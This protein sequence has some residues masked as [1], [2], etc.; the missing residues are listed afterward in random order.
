MNASLLDMLD[1][2][3]N[4]DGPTLEQIRAQAQAEADA[5]GIPIAIGW[6]V[7]DTTGEKEYGYCPASVAPSNAFVVEVLETVQPYRGGRADYATRQEAR[8]DRLE[9]AADRARS[10]S[11]SRFKRARG[12]L[13]G[14]EP[15]QPILVGHHSERRHR[16]ALEK[17]DTNM[18]AAIDADERAKDLAGRAAGVGT[19]GI[20]S[21]D[22]EALVKLREKLAGMEAEQ[23]RMKQANQVIRKWLKK[24]RARCIAELVKQGFTESLAGKLLEPDFC[25]RIGFADYQTKNNNA[26][27]RRVRERIEHLTRLAANTEEG[28]QARSKCGTVVY[29]IGDNRVQIVFPGKPKPE[30]RER[31][32]AAGFRWAP[33]AGAW[34]RHLNNAGKYH[35]G[36]FI[37]WFDQHQ[38]AA[39]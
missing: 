17:H 37:K 18:R 13:D 22:P 16:R 36:E 4:E 9:N 31:L 19:G 24:D 15:G 12:A 25:G 6:Q 7:N 33:S 21:D 32:K 26:N 11:A 34:Q 1:R 8:R 23:T 39:S 27:M 10:E 35:A 14:I 29:Q 28:E 20:S 38:Q 2:P 5:S 30:I 3:E